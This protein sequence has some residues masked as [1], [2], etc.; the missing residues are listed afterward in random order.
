MGFIE[1]IKEGSGKHVWLKYV[2]VNNFGSFHVVQ[3]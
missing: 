1:I 3:P 2:F